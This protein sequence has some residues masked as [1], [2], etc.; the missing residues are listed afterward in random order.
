[1]KAPDRPAGQARTPRP[2]RP[3][4]DPRRAPGGGAEQRG[5][6]SSET[7]KLSGN[8]TAAARAWMMSASAATRAQNGHSLTWCI[9]HDRSAMPLA[10]SAGSLRRRTT[11]DIRPLSVACAVRAGGVFR[12]HVSQSILSVALFCAPGPAAV[13]TGESHSVPA[14]ACSRRVRAAR[15]PGVRVSRRAVSAGARHGDG[16]GGGSA[17]ASQLEPARRLR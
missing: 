16:S 6:A 15:R 12:L 7:G 8:A 1:M 3:R 4:R 17:T 14:P 10:N 5:H 13:A 11:F 9:S 2:T